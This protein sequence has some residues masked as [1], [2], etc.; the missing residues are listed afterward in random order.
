LLKHLPSLAVRPLPDERRDRIEGLAETARYVEWDYPEYV[1]E[2]TF[3]AF[4]VPR[5]KAAPDFSGYRHLIVSPFCNDDGVARVRGGNT[6]DVTLVSRTETLDQLAPET[7]AGS[8]TRI[9]DPLA[10]LNDPDEDAVAGSASGSTRAAEVDTLFGLHAKVTVVERA[11]RG[12]V[13]VG[14]PN[15]TSAAFDGN[16][17]FAVELSGGAK[18]LGVDNF[19]GA[20]AGFAQLLMDYTADGSAPPDP[21]EEL[22]RQLMNVLRGLAEVPFTLT[23]HPGQGRH[24][25]QLRSE[26]PIG[27]PRG[28][29]VRAELLTNPGMVRELPAGKA[30]DVAFPS[31]PLPDVT[32]FVVLRAND[33]K[34][35]TA[36]N[37]IEL[38]TVVHAVLIN[39]PPNRL[40]EVLARQVDTPEKFLHFLALLLGLGDAAWLLS[41]TDGG[42]FGKGDWRSGAGEWRL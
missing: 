18:R 13:F 16:V 39:D 33:A 11:K 1:D 10:V 12:H 28:C 29:V 14:S 7:L 37:L 4:G 23:V 24:D 36:S 21:S 40:D 15:A 26:K 38:S 27:P 42:V 2:I 31:V 9:L 17:E 25:L 22:L 3:H 41:G 19:L 30:A 6:R 8:K 20:D 5:L 34:H 32:P 35:S